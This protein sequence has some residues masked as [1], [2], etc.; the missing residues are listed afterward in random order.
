MS[1]P[2]ELLFR[3]KKDG[4]FSGGHTIR[5]NDDGSIG[6]PEPL[7]KDTNFPFV[8]IAAEINT[9]LVDAVAAANIDKDTQIAAANTDRDNVIAKYQSVIDAL[10]H[11]E[12]TKEDALNE[13]NKEAK[14]REID[15]LTKQKLDIEAKLAELLK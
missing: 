11:P 4:I 14:Q 6:D 8:D 15:E 12:K 10:Q 2:Y 9:A 5:I 7:G 1:K 3:W 13:L